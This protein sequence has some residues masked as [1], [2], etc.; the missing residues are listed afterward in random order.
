MKIKNCFWIIGFFWSLALMSCYDDEGN[1][2]YKDIEQTYVYDGFENSYQKSVGDLLEIIPTIVNAGDAWGDTARYEYWWT[3]QREL[4]RQGM[5]NQQYVIGQGPSLYYQI[6]LPD[7]SP[8]KYLITLHMKDKETGI[9]WTKTTYLKIT[10]SLPEGWLMLCDRKGKAE[11]NMY[12][13]KS[14]GTM[15]LVKDMLEKSGFPYVG[16]PRKV[17]YEKNV[18]STD[19]NKI[20][21]LTDQGTGWLTKGDYQWKEDQLMKYK[22]LTPVG[23]DYTCANIAVFNNVI[24]QM[25]DEAHGSGLQAYTPQNMGSIY[26]GNIAVYD[27]GTSGFSITPY[28]GGN[29]TNPTVMGG[30]VYDRD[31]RQFAYCSVNQGTLPEECIRLSDNPKWQVGKEMLYMQST[32]SND[33]IF[34]LF[35]AG[36]S[37]DIMECELAIQSQ[38]DVPSLSFKSV[39]VYRSDRILPNATHLKNAR[40]RA[41][42]MTTGYLYYVEGN[43]LY[44]WYDGRERMLRTFDEEVTALCC[45]YVNDNGNTQESK[46]LLVATYKEDPALPEEKWGNLYFFTTD[47][48]AAINLNQKNKV[49]GVGKVIDIDYQLK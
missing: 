9:K 41:Y 8:D 19:G 18:N 7:I 1:Y 47:G 21:I 29:Y 17:V 31:N 13:R 15:V 32:I 14:D 43:T 23:E 42:H 49:A 34:A 26:A 44:A 37:D 20:W 39:P 6:D 35:K 12:A 30:I 38:F 40:F 46:Y 10:G 45:E 24:F 2:D 11:L 3:A 27:K 48:E 5:N 28:I 16:G 33:R 25:G 22:M 4:Y 36:E